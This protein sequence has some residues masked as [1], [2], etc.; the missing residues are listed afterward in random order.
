VLAQRGLTAVWRSNDPAIDKDDGIDPSIIADDYVTDALP[1]AEG[2][3]LVWASPDPPA[4]PQPGTPLADY[5]ARLDR[6][7]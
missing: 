1:V 4:Q 7:C 3:V 2:Q 6:G 5:F